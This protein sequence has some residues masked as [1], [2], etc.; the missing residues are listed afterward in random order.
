MISA[1]TNQGKV[2]FMMY[3]ETMASD[4]LIKF[5][6]RLV[7]D[8]GRKVFL[9][10]DNLRVHHGK[11]VKEWLEKNK[12]QIE[13]FYLPSYSPELNPDEYLNGDLKNKVHTGMPPRSE[14][15]LTQKTRSFM[16]KLQRRPNHVRNYFKHPRIAYAA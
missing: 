3:R 14:K 16:K 2:R 10:L 11:A 6:S 1:I 9:I 4:I 13:V 8:A 5:M 7:K 15:E 12:E